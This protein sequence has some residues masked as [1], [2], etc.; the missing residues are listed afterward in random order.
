MVPHIP[1]DL[2]EY[3]NKQYPERCPN[4]KQSERDIWRYVGARELVRHL[5]QLYDEQLQKAMLK[6]K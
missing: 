1:N 3:L 4:V 5:N 2:L 6:D